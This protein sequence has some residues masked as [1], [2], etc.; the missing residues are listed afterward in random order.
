MRAANRFCADFRQADGTNITRFDEIRDGANR[1]LD[2]YRRVES[3]RPINVDGVNG[4]PF[5]RIREKIL[6]SGRSCIDAQPRIVGVA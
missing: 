1:F 5:E 2:G 4:E 3:R 6:H